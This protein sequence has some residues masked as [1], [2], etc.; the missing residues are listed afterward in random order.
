MSRWRIRSPPSTWPPNPRRARRR[1]RTWTI[2]SSPIRCRIPGRRRKTAFPVDP[3]QPEPHPKAAT[4]DDVSFD[5]V[6]SSSSSASVAGGAGARP[7]RFRRRGSQARKEEQ[8]AAAA[9]DWQVGPRARRDAVARRFLA[10]QGAGKPQAAGQGAQEAR[11]RRACR[12]PACRARQPEGRAGGGH[13][14][15]QR[16]EIAHR[17]RKAPLPRARGAGA[18]ARGRDRAR[19]PRP[20]HARG[21]LLDEHATCRRR[22][23]PAR[24]RPR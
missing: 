11:P 18:G 19:H 15:G 1:R 3:P 4:A 9:D 10:G 12:A 23:R 7:A 17:S 8:A 20:H 5:F 14:Q 24:Q 6:D 16:A 2:C 21:P 22:R 13:F